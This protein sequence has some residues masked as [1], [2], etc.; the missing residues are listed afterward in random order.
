MVSRSRADA[1]MPMS[2]MKARAS[3]GSS[4]SSSISNLPAN[5][6]PLWSLQILASSSAFRP[7]VSSSELRTTSTGLSARKRMPRTDFSSSGVRGGGVRRS[8]ESRKAAILVRASR[9]VSSAGVLAPR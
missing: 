7:K 3:S 2:S 5:S 6:I 8:P 4:R 9:S 1:A